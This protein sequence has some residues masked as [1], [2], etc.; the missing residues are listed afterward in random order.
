MIKKGKIAAIDIG[1]NSFHLIIAELK[2]RNEI[3]IIQEERE[4][5][6][7]GISEKGNKKIISDSSIQ[8]S[9]RTLKRFKSIADSHDATIRA[10][11]TSAL[12]EAKNRSEYVKIIKEATNVE[13]ETITG[14]EEARLIYLGISK[15]LSFEDE[16]VFCFDIGGGSVE[17]IA[18]NKDEIFYSH[19]LDIGAVRL[20]NM[21]FKDG[22]V[23]DENVNQCSEYVE[24][25]LSPIAKEIRK[26]DFR[27][28]VASS[29]TGLA[30]ASMIYAKKYNET[31]DRNKLNNYMIS[32][33]EL[34]ELKREALRLKTVDEREKISGLETVRAD[35]IPAGII[36]LSAIIELFDVDKLTVSSY[37]LR[38][39]IVF[40]SL[41]TIQ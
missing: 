35:I 11:A 1:A 22:I 15:A 40:D 37:A 23:T 30:A 4:I 25:N 39:G 32:K 19:S 7:L 2:N 38:E 5:I 18:G 31:P 28:T 17:F 24:R 16:T 13:I 29:G 41:R 21:F 3:K 36:L 27:K 26:F 9:I 8:K 20:T 12:R 34:M 6:R 14:I 33:N 10:V